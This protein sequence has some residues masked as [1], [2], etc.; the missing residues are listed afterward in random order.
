M[1]AAQCCVLEAKLSGVN[2]MQSR[3]EMKC[4]MLGGKQRRKKK[5]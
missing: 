3:S 4:P 5:I 2:E 1:L